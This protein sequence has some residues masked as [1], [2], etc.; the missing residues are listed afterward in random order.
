MSWRRGWQPLE[1]LELKAGA[2]QFFWSSQS[3]SLQ[4]DFSARLYIVNMLPI[5]GLRYHF[6]E[7]EFTF[8]PKIHDCEDHFMTY[9]Y[10]CKFGFLNHNT[11]SV[12][13]ML[14]YLYKYPKFWL[15]FLLLILYIFTQT[16]TLWWL[17]S[18][19]VL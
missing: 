2:M 7:L 14:M 18:I 11:V 6:L 15:I 13:S 17:V 8:L 9:I 16:P 5:C 12:Q 19:V 10:D 4:F 3:S 1:I